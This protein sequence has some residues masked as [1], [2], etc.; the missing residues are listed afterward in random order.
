MKRFAAQ[1]GMLVLL[2]A[3]VISVPLPA[4][5]AAG[6]GYPAPLTPTGKPLSLTILSPGGSF[7]PWWFSW[8]FHAPLWD[9]SQWTVDPATGDA[10]SFDGAY[11]HL[12]TGPLNMPT[13]VHSGDFPAPCTVIQSSQ[14]GTPTGLVKPGG[15]F[16]GA[17]LRCTRPDMKAG[18][19]SLGFPY[20]SRLQDYEWFPGLIVNLDQNLPANSPILSDPALYLGRGGQ[21]RFQARL[22]DESA[23]LVGTSLTLLRYSTLDFWSAPSTASRLT[24]QLDPLQIRWNGSLPAARGQT[25]AWYMLEYQFYIGYDPDTGT[26]ATGE[27]RSLDEDPKGVKATSG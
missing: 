8:A 6:A 4:A 17:G 15:I 1:R 26:G 23:R 5:G 19:A 27:I 21:D 20:A 2:L 13:I 14:G 9:V 11:V 7:Q 18:L 24:L 22:L 16:K 25:Y 10:L 12:E 3:L